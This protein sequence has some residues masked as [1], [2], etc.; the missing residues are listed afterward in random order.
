M[1]AKIHINARN[2]DRSLQKEL[3][4][5]NV[6]VKYITIAFMTKNKIQ[7]YEN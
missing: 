3:S 1:T 6:V 7:Q 4:Q 2:Y 5:S